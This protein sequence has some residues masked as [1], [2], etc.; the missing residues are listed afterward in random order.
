MAPEPG[1]QS[2]EG[3][4][5]GMLRG[6]VFFFRKLLGLEIYQDPT[7]VNSRFYQKKLGKPDRIVDTN[8]SHLFSKKSIGFQ[9]HVL[10][11]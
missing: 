8:I 7:I 10:I 6:R 5:V 4:G 3:V 11:Y 9:K 1:D 2:N